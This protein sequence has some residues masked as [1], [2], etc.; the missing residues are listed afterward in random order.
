MINHIAENAINGKVTIA[1]FIDLSK[2]FDCLQYPQLFR[3]MAALG[4]TEAT[5]NWFKSYLSDRKQIT[6]VDGTTSTEQKVNLGV[7]QGSILG[8]ILFLIYVNDMNN[9][10]QSAT[11]LK[12][13]DDTTILTHGDTLDEAVEKMNY[14][15][16]KVSRWFQRNKLNLN[17]SKTRYMLFNSHTAETN[18]V[19]IGQE[20]IER[21]WENGKEKA[22]KLVGL[23]LDE[24]LKWTHHIGYILK[25]INSSNYALTKASKTLNTKNKKL[26]Y[27]GLVHS[28]LVYGLPIWGHA[29]PGRL[30]PLLTRQKQSIR[31]IYNLQYR[32]HTMQYFV[33]SNILQLPE[34]IKHQTL[35][36]IHSGINGPPNV[37][38]LW[39]MYNNPR[40][41]TRTSEKQLTYK[42]THL[43]W[44]HNLAPIAQVKLWNRNLREGLDW[45]VTPLTYKF[46]SK[47]KLMQIYHDILQEQGIFVTN[48][49]N[50]SN[51][52]PRNNTNYVVNYLALAE[53]KDD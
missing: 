47:T 26:V 43:Q 3:K 12:F 7:P 29:T 41:D 35:C 37:Q 16:D 53:F 48:D 11:F 14:S 10:D 42:S 25:K 20:F 2:A 38:Q 44:I 24:K 13:A 32:D 19:K 31:K 34:L 8:P 18:L 40:G 30:K 1:T 45:R 5:L 17:P 51:S 49:I 39:T 21:V 27:S 4:F 6:D 22:F 23:Q 36:Y 33:K 50:L 46:H 52:K 15:L 28:H 9:S